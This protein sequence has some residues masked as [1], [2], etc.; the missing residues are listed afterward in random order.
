V[1][2]TTQANAYIESN[3]AR[4]GWSTTD[5]DN[6]YGE[7]TVLYSGLFS[8][9]PWVGAIRTSD[10]QLTHAEDIWTYLNLRDVATELAG[11]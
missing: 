3:N 11:E 10:M 4:F 6:S 7:N 1:S 9:L 5:S 8:A 2:S